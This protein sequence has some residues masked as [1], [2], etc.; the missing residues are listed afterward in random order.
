MD[1]VAILG[2]V[3]VV[4][5]TA[6]AGVLVD[7]YVTPVLPRGEDL[8]GATRHA[9][10]PG[11]APASAI[12]CGAWRRRWICGGQRCDCGRRLH[13]AGEET[14]RL[15]DEDLLVVRLACADCRASRSLYF[16]ARPPRP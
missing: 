9:H 14:A 11:T 6:A 2:T 7:R 12:R 10:A 3:A 16:A 1:V 8:S 13:P 5:G 4:A 15:G